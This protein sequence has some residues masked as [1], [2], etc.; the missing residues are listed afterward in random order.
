MKQHL[1]YMIDSYSTCYAGDA[2]PR[3]RLCVFRSLIDL[4]VMYTIQW[5]VGYG[6]TTLK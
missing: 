1:C 5:L 4:S 6:H 3:L 2:H